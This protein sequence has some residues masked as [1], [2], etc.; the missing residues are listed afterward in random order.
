MRDGCVNDTIVENL[1]ACRLFWR[2]RLKR[3]PVHPQ[4]VVAH[5]S[6]PMADGTLV[7]NNEAPRSQP[8]DLVVEACCGL[9]KGRCLLG[10]SFMVLDRDTERPSTANAGRAW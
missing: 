6:E 10:A 1:V 8:A 3:Q 9:A 7:P 2:G 4:P 5:C